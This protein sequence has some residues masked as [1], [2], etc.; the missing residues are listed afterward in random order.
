M[1]QLPMLENTK[2]RDPKQKKTARPK[3]PIIPMGVR[4]AINYLET[5]SSSCLEG[6]CAPPGR[7]SATFSFRSLLRYANPQYKNTSMATRS[8]PPRLTS[9][10][11]G[12]TSRGLPS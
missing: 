6:V 8:G 9:P 10:G 4:K 3:L 12:M 2:K 5:P 11:M 1:P 7:Q